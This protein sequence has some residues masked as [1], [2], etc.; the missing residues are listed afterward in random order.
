VATSVTTNIS[1][2]FQN[3]LSCYIVTDVQ[4]LSFK[5]I[6]NGV[7]IGHFVNDNIVS[8]E[9]NSN[10]ITIKTKDDVFYT[11]LFVTVSECLLA[12]VRINDNMNGGITTGC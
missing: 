5:I 12:D 8:W 10:V 6:A 2:P 4:N 3:L 9:V 7:V 1:N 11:L